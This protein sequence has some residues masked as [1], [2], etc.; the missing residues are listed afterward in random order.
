V[1][2]AID[3]CRSDFDASQFS[4]NSNAS[5]WSDLAMTNPDRTELF[6][7]LADLSRRYPHW[8]IGQL[9]ANVAGWADAEIWDA[10]DDQL[11]AAIR[12]HLGS[13]TF[14]KA[15]PATPNLEI[16]PTVPDVIVPKG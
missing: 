16:S 11:L 9:L 14:S 15:S 2:R 13:S 7:A 3:T 1:S 8:R 6:S 12:A 5:R 10:E 4:R